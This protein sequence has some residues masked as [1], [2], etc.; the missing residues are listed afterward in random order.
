MNIFN[1]PTAYQVS[2]VFPSPAL[3]PLVLSKFLA[4][5]FISQFRLLI[6]MAPQW[7]KA[8][9]LLTV[10]N[11]FADVPY[12]CP[13]AKNIIMDVSVGWVCKALQLLHLILW[14]LRDVCWTDKG[15]LPH[16]VK[17][18]QG[19]LDPLHQRV[20]QQCWNK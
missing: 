17:Q 14:L 16:S 11:M 19:Q 4:E 10:F 18:W 7:M 8:P 9:W 13:I 12:Q 5:H 3:V 2:N 15:A 20:Y 6:L 1:H